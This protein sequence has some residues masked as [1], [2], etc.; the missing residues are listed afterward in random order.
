MSNGSKEV[1]KKKR[2]ENSMKTQKKICSTVFIAL[3]FIAFTLLVGCSPEKSDWSKT[4]AEDD[5]SAY[6]E[7]ME[8]YPNGKFIEKAKENIRKLMGQIVFTSSRDG[9]NEIYIMNADGTDVVRLTDNTFEDENPVWSPDSKHIAFMSDRTGNRE[10]FIMKADGSDVKQLTDNSANDTSPT[11]SPDGRHIAFVSERSDNNEIYIMNADGTDKRN[12][13]NH[14]AWDISPAWSPDGQQIAFA[15]YRYKTLE[16]CVVNTDGSNLQ[17]LTNNP[18][19]NWAPSWSPDGRRIA[20]VSGSVDSRT[21]I[22][23]II[24]TIANMY[25]SGNDIS[26]IRK[27][28]ENICIMNADGSGMKTLTANTSFSIRQPAWSPDGQRITVVSDNNSNHEIYIINADG[29]NPINITKNPK[30]DY[31][32]D[33]SK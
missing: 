13:T 2:G 28:I 30:G 16:I 3:L 24:L 29:T 32:P 9:N 14:P 5:I 7:F 26:S 21:N 33:W 11:W 1:L 20:F 27:S 15:S 12:L 23:R 22:R 6:E 4:K 18:T 17:R 19:F 8:K 25:L 31:C 10:I